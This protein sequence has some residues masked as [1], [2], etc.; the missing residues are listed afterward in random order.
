MND[1]ERL[2]IVSVVKEWLETMDSVLLTSDEKAYYEWAA[3]EIL[4]YILSHTKMT[5]VQ[6]VL[7][8]SDLMRTYM[9]ENRETSYIFSF[10]YDA[11]TAIYGMLVNLGLDALERSPF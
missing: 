8:F 5:P 2:T 6:S 1:D 7:D 11:A 9:S 3:D 10:A 4:V